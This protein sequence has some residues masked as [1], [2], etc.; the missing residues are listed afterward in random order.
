MG[1]CPPW[2]LPRSAAPCA[3]S[4][5]I[6]F[7]VNT[8]APEPACKTAHEINRIARRERITDSPKDRLLEP[9]FLGFGTREKGECEKYTITRSPGRHFIA[10]LLQA[11]N[12][13]AP[14][15]H[16]RGMVPHQRRR[17]LHRPAA[18]APAPLTSASTTV[19][20]SGES[21]QPVCAWRGRARA[22]IAAKAS[23]NIVFF[24]F[25]V[26]SNFCLSCRLASCSSQVS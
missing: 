25:I 20:S 22:S 19:G 12:L 16:C 23:A 10:R 5:W 15:A 14:E 8:G 13:I 7:V 18:T 24:R 9:P 4:G 26:T 6:G 21:S 11:R 17:D 2:T 3:R 1:C